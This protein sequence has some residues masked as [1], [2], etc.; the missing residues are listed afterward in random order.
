MRFSCNFSH[1]AQVLTFT[2][3]LKFEQLT[4]ELVESEFKLEPHIPTQLSLFKSN[5]SDPRL[6]CTLNY[7]IVFNFMQAYIHLSYWTHYLSMW[8]KTEWIKTDCSYYKKQNKNHSR[9]RKKILLA[10]NYKLRSGKPL[11]AKLSGWGPLIESKTGLLLSSA[12]LRSW[13][14]EKKDLAVVGLIWW[15]LGS[16]PIC[17]SFRFRWVFQ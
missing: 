5:N 11:T 14:F 1:R 12:E 9:Q 6:I 10:S 15:F 3:E 7:I 2:L 16:I 17:S 13:L 8:N 4:Y